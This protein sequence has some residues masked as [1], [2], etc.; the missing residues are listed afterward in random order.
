[1]GLNTDSKIHVCHNYNNILNTCFEYFSYFLL[2]DGTKGLT[3]VSK[4]HAYHNDKFLK[5][6]FDY[7]L[8][9][10]FVMVQRA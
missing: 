4:I 1:M 2:Q 8:I 7:F 9:S 3:T 6:C 10:Y 5:I